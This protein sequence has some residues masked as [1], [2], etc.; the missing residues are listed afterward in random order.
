MAYPSPTL[1]HIDYLD[2]F[3]TYLQWLQITATV[4]TAIAIGSLTA[5]IGW[6]Q[7]D[8]ARDQREIARQQKEIANAKLKLDLFERRFKIFD[9]VWTTVSDT[10]SYGPRNTDKFPL[11]GLGR[12]GTP[13]NFY[14]PEAAFLFGSEIAAYIKELAMKWAQFYYLEGLAVGETRV[15]EA[16]TLQAYFE[17][18]L[19]HGVY[20]KFS[21]FLNFESWK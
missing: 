6:K 16:K 7:K 14:Q 5:F 15:E 13:F 2:W 9:Q 21:P 12:L 11:V 20:D 17:D 4:F 1:S 18:Q 3:K 10:F 8:I 19:S